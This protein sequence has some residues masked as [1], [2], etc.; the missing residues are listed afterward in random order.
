MINSVSYLA[1]HGL[2]D[3]LSTS[4]VMAG[5]LIVLM[6]LVAGLTVYVMK[7]LQ[8]IRK[9]YNRYQITHAIDLSIELLKGSYCTG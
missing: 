1:T 9:H 5:Y 4:G 3:S 2:L 8:L 6:L 7:A